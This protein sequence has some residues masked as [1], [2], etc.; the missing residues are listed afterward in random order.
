KAPAQQAAIGTLVGWCL[1]RCLRTL[2]HLPGQIAHRAFGQVLQ[3]PLQRVT[4][5]IQ[6]LLM[7]VAFAGK[8]LGGIQIID[9]DMPQAGGLPAFMHFAGIEHG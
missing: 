6:R 9:A 8:D 2:G 7:P 4:A 3:P 5:L 1:L